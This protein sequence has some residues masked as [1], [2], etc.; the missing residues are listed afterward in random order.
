MG[1]GSFLHLSGEI[2]F[3]WVT[4]TETNTYLD[5][6]EE[7]DQISLFSTSSQETGAQLGAKEY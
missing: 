1:V 7:P 3:G 4:V 2:K 5:D 6:T